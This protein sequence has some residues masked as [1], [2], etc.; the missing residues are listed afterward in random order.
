MADVF[1]AAVLLGVFAMKN[2][3]AT[4]A[5]P[6]IGLYYFAGYCLL[7]MMTTVLLSGSQFVKEAE[8]Q[9]NEGRDLTSRL[10]FAA[11]GC[12]LCVALVLAVVS[13]IRQYEQSA[14]TPPVPVQEASAWT[15]TRAPKPKRQQFTGLVELI[16]DKAGTIVVK[17]GSE[18]KAFKIG[19]KTK[20]STTDKPKD[21][22]LTD[23]EVG[24]KVLVHYT[25]EDGVLT[26]HHI[27]VP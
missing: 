7:S 20:Y 3:Q 6:C 19:E 16:D 14:V 17:K 15:D 23:I 9:V 22:A 1:V 5:F 25:E 2:Q 18:S 4:R 13:V 21:A 26:A 27:G 8:S 11:V 24:D 10:E 12:L